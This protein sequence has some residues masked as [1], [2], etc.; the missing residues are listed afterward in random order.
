MFSRLDAPAAPS[1]LLAAAIHECTAPLARD[2]D[3]ARR[4]RG[5]RALLTELLYRAPCPDD[6][7][8]I[9][10]LIGRVDEELRELAGD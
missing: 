1:P 8:R 6:F 7:L 3:D 5:T 10:R 4:L 2:A 9:A